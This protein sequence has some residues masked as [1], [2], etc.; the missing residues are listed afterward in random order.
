MECYVCWILTA[1]SIIW[2]CAAGPEPRISVIDDV[3]STTVRYERVSTLSSRSPFA[4]PF[5]RPQNP[6]AG[7]ELGYGTDCNDSGRL[8]H[9]MS[10]PYTRQDSNQKYWL[11][12]SKSDISS[13]LHTD[14]H[15]HNITGRP[16]RRL[17]RCRRPFQCSSSRRFYYLSRSSN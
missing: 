1:D 15:S 9:C 16:S 3:S 7:Y 4:L 2:V 6:S 10:D 11:S 17:K 13:P 8:D 12:A 5:R 14:H